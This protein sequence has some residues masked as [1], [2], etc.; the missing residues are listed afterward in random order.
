MTQRDAAIQVFF[1]QLILAS[2]VIDVIG[3][4]ATSSNNVF[5]T[6]P[7]QID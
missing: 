7:H 5:L 6:R 3:V 2:D 4:N 1:C